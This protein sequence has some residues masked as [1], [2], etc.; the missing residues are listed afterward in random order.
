ME[1]TLIKEKQ[2]AGQLLV[3]NLL[4]T[5]AELARMLFDRVGHRDWLNAYLLAAGMQQILEDYLQPDP[6]MLGKV[7]KNL[8]KLAKP[9]GPL[10]ASAALRTGKLLCQFRLYRAWSNTRPL[11]HWQTRL[12]GFVERLAEVLV[13]GTAT[14]GDITGFEVFIQELKTGLDRDSFPAALCQQL[15][16]LPSCFRSFDQQPTDLEQVVSRFEEKWPGQKNRPLLVVGIRTSGSYLAPLY[17]AFLKKAGYC[18]VKWLTIR[19]W[20]SL[21]GREIDCIKALNRSQGLA[22]LVD[23]PPTTGRSVAAV[24][25]TLQRAGLSATNLVLFLQ[26]FKEG[27][28]GQVRLPPALNKYL[29]VLLGWPEWTIQQ[30]LKPEE[31]QRA[32]NDLLGPDVWV[33][34]VEALPIP[35]ASPGSHW[36]R[37]HGRALFRVHLEEYGNMRRRYQDILVSGVGL[38]YFG[39]AAFAVAR[40][41]SS[42]FP[43]IYGLKDGLLYRAWLPEAN[44]LSNS[45]LEYLPELAGYLARYIADRNQALPVPEDYSLRLDGQQPVWEA[46]SQILFQAYTPLRPA[47]MP[48][49]KMIYPEVKRLLQVKRPGVIDGSMGLENWFANY[50]P[51]QPL[52]KVNFDYRAFSNLDMSC[53]DPV[54]DLAGLAASAALAYQQAGFPDDSFSKLLLETY[55]RLTGETIEPERWLVYRL[56]YFH[57]RA[58]LHVSEQSAL[59]RAAARAVQDYYSRVFFDDLPVRESGA[60]CALDIDGVLETDQLGFPA[61]SPTSALTLR[62]LILHGYRPVLVSGRS[63]PEIKE[64][65][66]AYHLPGGVG[67]YGSVIYNHLK[68]EE[69]VLLSDEQLAKV[70]RLRA[71]LQT[72]DGISLD[73]DYHYSVRAY[74]LDESGRRRRLEAKTVRSALSAAGFGPET[75]CAARIRPVPG[76][77]QTDFVAAGIDKGTG[78]KALATELSSKQPERDTPALDLRL[79]VGDTI[80]D[81]PML[82]LAATFFAPAQARKSPAICKAA[83]PIMSRP[84]QAGLAQGVSVLLAHRPGNCKLCRVTKIPANAPTRQFLRLLA[85]MDK[86]SGAKLTQVLFQRR[87]PL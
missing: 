70:Q 81:L 25:Q 38:G 11:L 44:K 48:F 23:D 56:V 37:G 20:H 64:R 29:A 42:Y 86:G 28:G 21:P 82:K 66:K 9:F 50:T 55:S 80:S 78:L 5:Y 53:Y 54:Y 73:P 61:L 18:R 76:D 60:L 85:A 30:Q 59:C 72:Y 16:R 33:K 87:Q 31:V 17:A 8:E 39:E 62:A 67:E 46:A 77:G 35:H 47:T 6:F 40:P 65:C 79:A 84:Y 58:R 4:N 27:D 41:L 19:P 32:L 75:V 7:A 51:G 83:I 45:N 2:P 63:L 22:I 71:V 69:K 74:R 15:L 36:E 12:A 52:L 3:P 34:S 1:Q 13:A 10:G 43:P 26:L 57:D 49:V 24:A 14:P 68:N